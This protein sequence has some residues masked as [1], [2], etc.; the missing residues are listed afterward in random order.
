MKRMTKSIELDIFVGTW[1]VNSQEPLEE[2]RKSVNANYH[3]THRQ[4]QHGQLFGDISNENDNISPLTDI[5]ND[6]LRIEDQ[7][8]KVRADI[9]RDIGQ[10]LQLDKRLADIYAIGFQVSF[11]VLAQREYLPECLCYLLCKTF[12]KLK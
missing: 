2:Y 9:A 3:Q 1:N 8:Y 4:T 7:E 12:R 10:W 6:I 11:V 5:P